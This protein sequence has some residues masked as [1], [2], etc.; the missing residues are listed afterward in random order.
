MQRRNQMISDEK[1]KGLMVGVIGAVE[2]VGRILA[3]EN[4]NVSDL[5][6]DDQDEIEEEMQEMLEGLHPLRQRSIYDIFPV[7]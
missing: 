2:G 7:L 5:S 4:E 3:M 6:G 1:K